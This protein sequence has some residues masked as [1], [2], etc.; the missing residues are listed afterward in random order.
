MRDN[1][2]IDLT[3]RRCASS[4]TALFRTRS[5]GNQA[6]LPALENAPRPAPWISRAQPHGGRAQGV[7]QP[8]GPWPAAARAIGVAGA[9]KQRFGLD[10]FRRVGQK[11][12]FER[13]LRSGTRRSVGGYVFYYEHRVAG[14]PRLGILISR[15][16]AASAV[17]RNR[18]KRCIREA[19]R[20]EQHSLGAV[21][22]LVRPPYGGRGSSE[23]ARTLRKLLRNLA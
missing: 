5:N 11:A 1:A 22:L 4:N 19:F 17:Q 2:A 23:M 10:A 15:K 21:D 14:P 6:D 16:H 13:L 9:V 8:P 20:L 12:V 7:A 3:T 18:I